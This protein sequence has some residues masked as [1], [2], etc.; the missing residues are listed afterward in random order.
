MF[1]LRVKFGKLNLKSYISMCTHQCDHD[2]LEVASD[3]MHLNY[4]VSAAVVEVNADVW[5]LVA[6][7]DKLVDTV[8][9]VMV[10]IRAVAL[11]ANQS[12]TMGFPFE[13]CADL[14]N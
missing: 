14:L 10:H 4:D 9:T 7:V 3:K 1:C 12:M 2:A 8:D 11:L 13:H 5:V 6:A